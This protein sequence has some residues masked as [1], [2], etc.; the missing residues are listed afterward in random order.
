MQALA[1]LHREVHIIP[2]KTLG[3]VHIKSTKTLW[4]FSVKKVLK[5]VGGL[6]YSLGSTPL[7][8]PPWVR[9]SSLPP[10]FSVGVVLLCPDG[11][12]SLTPWLYSIPMGIKNPPP[13]ESGGH[14]SRTLLS[15]GLRS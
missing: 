2:T 12:S 7:V 11:W 9:G 5:N 4:D 6:L 14:V 3:R 8:L 1:K 13:V 10:C 15:R